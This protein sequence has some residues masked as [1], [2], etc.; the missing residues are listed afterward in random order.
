MKI[1]KLFFAL[2]FAFFAFGLNAQTVTPA[3]KGRQIQQQKRI[4]KGVKDEELSKKEVKTLQREQRR[5]NRS[6]NRAQ[7]DGK[8][9]MAE[10]AALHSR[11]NRASRRIKRAK[12]N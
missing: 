6:K 4:V 12:H 1:R 5:I 8:V 7:A 10:R 3:V 9:T 11:Q 2:C